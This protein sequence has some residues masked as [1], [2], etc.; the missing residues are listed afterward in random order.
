MDIYSINLLRS[1]YTCSRLFIIKFTCNFLN[2]Q[3][4]FR[5]YNM[6]EIIHITNSNKYPISNKSSLWFTIPPQCGATALCRGDQLCRTPGWSLNW[7]ERA[8]YSF[9]GL[10]NILTSIRYTTRPLHTLFNTKS[11]LSFKNSNGCYVIWK[12]LSAFDKIEPMISD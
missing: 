10:Y 6:S 1:M 4:T 11:R 2:M 5:I 7:L 3:S 8:A 9:S 12:N